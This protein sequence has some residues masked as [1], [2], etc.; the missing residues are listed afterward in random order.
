MVGPKGARLLLIADYDVITRRTP[1][2][3][4]TRWDSYPYPLRKSVTWRVTPKILPAIFRGASQPLDLGRSRRIASP[5]QRITLVAR[6]R[7]CIGCGASANWCQAHH[8]IPWA[9]PKAQP[10][11]TTCVCCAVPLPPQST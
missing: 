2:R 9:T 1:Q 5:A 8:I 4:P 7:K 10:T 6:D 3:A 11:S